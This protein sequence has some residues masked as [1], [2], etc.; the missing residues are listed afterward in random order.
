MM[1]EARRFSRRGRRTA[2]LALTP[3]LLALA[4]LAGAK[5]AAAQQ[6]W[7]DV[8]VYHSPN[9]DGVDP[10]SE[11]CPPGCLCDGGSGGTVTINF[12]DLDAYTVVTDQYPEATF[13]P[14][15]TVIWAFP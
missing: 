10:R 3:L 4:L 8:N 9:D 6:Q 14:D 15:D 13:I 7:P 1:F 12:D 11:T 5:P 2:A